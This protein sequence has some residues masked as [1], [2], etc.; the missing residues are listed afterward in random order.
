LAKKLTVRDLARDLAHVIKPGDDLQSIVMKHPDFSDFSYLKD[1][2]VKSFAYGPERVR[3]KTLH[4]LM[5]DLLDDLAPPMIAP[6]ARRCLRRYQ[7]FPAPTL[8]PQRRYRASVNGLGCGH[9][10]LQVKYKSLSFLVKV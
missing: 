7:P 5:V 9:V 4:G 6:P 10:L 8:M 2:S 3:L 1:G